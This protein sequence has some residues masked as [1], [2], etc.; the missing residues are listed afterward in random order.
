MNTTKEKHRELANQYF[1]QA[2]WSREYSTQ[3]YV[4]LF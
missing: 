2:A 4:E 1:E 3:G